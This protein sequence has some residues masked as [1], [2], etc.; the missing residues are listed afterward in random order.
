MTSRAL[1]SDI[2]RRCAR[3]KNREN[4]TD[5]GKNKETT[6]EIQQERKTRSVQFSSKSC[7]FFFLNHQNFS[8]NHN[9]EKQAGSFAEADLL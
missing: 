9:T 1:R 3:G 4:E 6:T 5:G 8:G 2:K 7:V